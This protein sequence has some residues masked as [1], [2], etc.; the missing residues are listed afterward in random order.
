MYARWCLGRLGPTLPVTLR[1]YLPLILVPNP[2]GLLIMV[3]IC[4]TTN[5]NGCIVA[6]CKSVLSVYMLCSMVPYK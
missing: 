4:A 6:E 2:F 5:C 1:R 3:H